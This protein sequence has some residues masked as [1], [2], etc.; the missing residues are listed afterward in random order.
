M[1]DEILQRFSELLEEYEYRILARTVGE[2]VNVNEVKHQLINM[3][4]Q[5]LDK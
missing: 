2:Y 4:R 1:D 5:I 3:F